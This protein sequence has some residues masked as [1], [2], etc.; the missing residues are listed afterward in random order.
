MSDYKMMSCNQCCHTGKDCDVCVSPGCGEPENLSIYSPIIY[1]EVGINLCRTIT[2]PENILT[3][4]P[5]TTYVQLLVADIKIYSGKGYFT[6]EEETVEYTEEE[7]AEMGNPPTFSTVSLE[8]VYLPAVGTTNY[9]PDTNP[10][11]VTVD[12]YAP[13]GAST[14]YN[15]Y[16]EYYINYVGFNMYDNTVENGLNMNAVAKVMEFNPTT[17]TMSAGITLYLRTVYYQAYKFNSLGKTMPPKMNTHEAE[18]NPCLKFVEGDL[19][20]NDVK[21]LELEPPMCEGETKREIK[22]NN[23]INQCL[24]EILN[25]CNSEDEE[26]DDKI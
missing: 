20:L 16:E 10:R 26:V 6:G 3:L 7:L 24:K 15:S 1:D 18:S 12:M 19:L 5:T 13:Y 4:Y 17:G 21:P 8:A 22:D 25:T 23:E 2:I 11:S 14:V 9:N